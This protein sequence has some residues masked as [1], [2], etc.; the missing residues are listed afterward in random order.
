MGKGFFNGQWSSLCQVDSGN[1]K[2][3]HIWFSIHPEPGSG[4]S[5]WRNNVTSSDFVSS[6]AKSYR[7]AIQSSWKRCHC[8]ESRETWRRGNLIQFSPNRMRLLRHDQMNCPWL[9]MTERTIQFLA[10]KDSVLRTDKDKS[11]WS[12]EQLAYKVFHS[13]LLPT[14]KKRIKEKGAQKEEIASHR[15]LSNLHAKRLA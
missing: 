8:E 11:M 15:S 1:N 6:R 13:F 10:F 12:I 14:Q 7:D 3:L 2:I 9:A 5:N 4:H